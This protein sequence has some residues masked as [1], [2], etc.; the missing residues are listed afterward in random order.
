[1]TVTRTGAFPVAWPDGPE[2]R[3]AG[4]DADVGRPAWIRARGK[5]EQDGRFSIA[6]VTN[7]RYVLWAYKER[8]T[9]QP[10]QIGEVH[11]DLNG[12]DVEQLFVRTADR[13][14]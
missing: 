3:G 14:R 11:F 9:E 5:T 7:G 12:A 10:A 8:T 6:G 13:V 4:R 1:M 2:G